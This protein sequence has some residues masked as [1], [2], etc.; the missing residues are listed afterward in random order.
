MIHPARLK[1][2]HPRVSV[3][4]L[5]QLL[6]GYTD[7]DVGRLKPQL[8]IRHTH[9]SGQRRVVP[10]TPIHILHSYDV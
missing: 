6:A 3:A 2:L 4:K 10:W 8:V 1:H 7:I 9:F 5:A